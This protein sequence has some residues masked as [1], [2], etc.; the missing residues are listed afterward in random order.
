[1]NVEIKFCSVI[2]NSLIEKLFLVQPRLDVLQL[3][4]TNN[5][6]A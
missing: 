6:T 2:W 4:N 1:M 5:A 3:L